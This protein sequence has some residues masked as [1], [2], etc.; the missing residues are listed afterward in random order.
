MVQYRSQEL[1]HVLKC[2][3]HRHYRQK[4]SEIDDRLYSVLDTVLIYGEDVCCSVVFGTLVDVSVFSV[5]WH[6]FLITSAI[7]CAL[8]SSMYE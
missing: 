8:W 4:E 3:G 5:I 2:M 6:E 1:Y 7:S